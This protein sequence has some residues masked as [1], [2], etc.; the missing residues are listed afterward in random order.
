MRFRVSSPLAVPQ[1]IVEEAADPLSILRDGE[2]LQVLVEATIGVDGSALLRLDAYQ[3]H[4]VGADNAVDREWR[5]RLIR[6]GHGIALRGRE[7]P[8]LQAGWGMAGVPSNFREPWALNERDQRI[9]FV[10]G[11]GTR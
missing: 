8:D 9:Y 7:A 1:Q 10:A 2:F 6:G 5:G 11:R 4:S 3:F